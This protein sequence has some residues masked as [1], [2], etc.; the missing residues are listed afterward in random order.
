MSQLNSVKVYSLLVK[1]YFYFRSENERLEWGLEMIEV[2]LLRIK[3]VG[4][5]MFVLVFFSVGFIY[6]DI[7]IKNTIQY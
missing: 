7:Q 4:Y 6:K 2:F 5:I 1:R 3:V